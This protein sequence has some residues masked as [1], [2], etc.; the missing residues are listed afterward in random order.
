[1]CDEGQ[2]GTGGAGRTARSRDRH[3]ARRAAVEALTQ[4][5]GVL[6]VS[7][8]S[9]Q[10][11]LG[12]GS[13]VRF[14]DRAPRIGDVVVFRRAGGDLVVHRFLGSRPA[15]M[16]AGGAAL[17]V[18]KP[19]AA[20]DFDVEVDWSAVLGTVAAVR[21]RVDEPWTDFVVSPRRRALCMLWLARYVMRRWVRRLSR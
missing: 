10:P 11:T 17:I 9:M 20:S 14:S 18:T 2:T 6:R 13:W 1:M 8:R 3:Q 4:E 7:G 12:E 19:D 5:S 15:W 21:P 16:N